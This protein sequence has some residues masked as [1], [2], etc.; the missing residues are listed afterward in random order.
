MGLNEVCFRLWI[1][2][3]LSN[4]STEY[5]LFYFAT[6]ANNLFFWTEFSIFSSS[7]S[8]IRCKFLVVVT[9][10]RDDSYLS[11][12]IGAQLLFIRRQVPR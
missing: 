12:G 5:F 8:S 6:P 10:E 11:F 3:K 9:G 2:C 4:F 1:F 7:S